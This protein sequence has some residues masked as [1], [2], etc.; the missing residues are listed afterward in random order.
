MEA[1]SLPRSVPE[2]EG[3]PSAAIESYL[4]GILDEHLA[5]H[6][7]MIMR[8][9]KIVFEKYWK[10]FDENFRHRLY[11]CSKSF[12]SVAIG[13]LIGR[14]VLSLDDKIVKFFPDKLAGR[15]VDP[16]LEGCTIRDLLRM[17]SPYTKGANYSANDPDW[18]ETFFNDD[19][20]HV[21]GAV[22][23]YCT[24]GTTILCHIIKRV[25]GKNFI[26]VLRPVFDE[27]GVGDGIFCVESPDGVEWGGSGVC[28][29]AE[30]FAKFAELCMNGGRCN[31][32]Q[33]IPAW[34]MQEATTRQIDN[35]L[36]ADTDEMGQGYGYQFWMMKNNGFAFYGMGGQYA[37]CFPEQELMV[38]TTGYEELKITARKHA[39]FSRLWE[40]IFPALSDGAL[41]EDPEANAR[42]EK[43]GDSLE[44]EHMRGEA[45]SPA[46]ED[47]NGKWYYMRENA[48]GMKKVKFEFADGKGVMCYENAAG[49]RELKFGMCR[50]VKQEFP[51]EYSGRRIATTYGK[52]YDSYNSAAWTMP[53][54][55]MIHCHIAD[56]YLGQ[57]RMAV[58]FKGDTVTLH[59]LKHAEWFID[60]YVGFASGRRIEG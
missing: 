44:L 5:M 41:P 8:H 51:E 10:P 34:Y 18:A 20:S 22:F 36:Y 25:T 15:T 17:S 29:T 30:E 1:R 31:G 43:L 53:D 21:P 13:Y 3:I 19:V 58:N 55:L 14:G 54:T 32:K 60:N 48:M 50:N 12:T 37:L 59:G 42:L 24:S 40:T 7:L 6:S 35:S 56:I 9:G 28:A 16:Y 4:R 39:I 45:C 52:G 11:S 33:L 2:R 46:A 57:L 47:V 49:Y 27:I 38:V 26:E 23:S